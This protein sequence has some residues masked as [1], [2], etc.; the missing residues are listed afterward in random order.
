MKNSRILYRTGNC[1]SLWSQNPTVTNDQ[2]RISPYN[3]NTTSS[4]PVINE[5]EEKYQLEDYK[6]IQYQI[7]QTNIMRTAWLTVWRITCEILG[8]KASMPSTILHCTTFQL[9]SYLNTF[10]TSSWK[11]SWTPSLVLALQKKKKKQ[12]FFIKNKT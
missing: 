5:N 12:D 9:P 3:Y 2:D 10:S 11:A 6:W 7:L 1:C 8:V 4:R